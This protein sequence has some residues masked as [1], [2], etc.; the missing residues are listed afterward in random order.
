M[1]KGN[2]KYMH[3]NFND[4]TLGVVLVD[5]RWPLSFPRGTLSAPNMEIF[6]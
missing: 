4:G 6:G 5:F 2:G 1:G 3:L